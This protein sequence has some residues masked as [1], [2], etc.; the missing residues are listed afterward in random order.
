MLMFDEATVA[1]LRDLNETNLPDILYVQEPVVT[2]EA[3]VLIE[4]DYVTKFTTPCRM[5]AVVKSFRMVDLITKEEQLAAA[6]YWLVVTKWN[7]DDVKP[8]AKFVVKGTWGTK[9]LLPMGTTG[10]LTVEVLRKWV[11]K[12]W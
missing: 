6:G 9:E 4:G 11:C 10:P 7:F 12:E 1:M 2:R 3:G 8:G 5:S